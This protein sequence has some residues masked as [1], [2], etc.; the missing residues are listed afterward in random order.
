MR[1]ELI[2]HLIARAPTLSAR[3]LVDIAEF[4]KLFGKAK[5]TIRDP[6]FDVFE[7]FARAAQ[8]RFR[9][10]SLATVPMAAPPNSLA[11]WP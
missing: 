9:R 11:T 2:K 4:G 1:D 5:R 7:P 3:D 6:R 10:I 8:I